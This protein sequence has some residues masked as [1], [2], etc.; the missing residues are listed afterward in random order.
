VTAVESALETAERDLPDGTRGSGVHRLPSTKRVTTSLLA[1]W[2]TLLV[3]FSALTYQLASGVFDGLT[4]AIREDLEWKTVRG[5]HD[6]AQGVDIGI[7]LQDEARISKAFGG[8]RGGR[9][10]MAIVAADADGNVVAQWGILPEPAAS[11]FSGLPNRVRSESRYLVS[12]APAATADR[13]V[14]R[15]ALAV[16]TARL[17]EGQTLRS[18]ILFTAGGASLVA[19]LLSLLFVNLY[20]RPVLN[21]SQRALDKLAELT[22]NLEKRVSDRTV[23]LALAN[24]KLRESLVK[25]HDTQRELV[26]SSRRTGMEDVATAVLHN[27][28]NVLNSVNVSACVISD[29]M[30]RSKV[31]RLADAVAILQT[32]EDPKAQQVPAYLSKLA[33]A[34]E[35]ERDTV[36]QE[37]DR[38]TRSVDHIKAV[39]TTQQAHARASL[40]VREPLQMQELIS[41]ALLVNQISYERHHIEILRELEELPPAMIDRHRV[42]QIL[43]NLLANAARAIKDG[44]RGDGR[45]TVRLQRI[46]PE[47]F[48]LEVEDTGVGIAPQ[49]AHLIFNHGFTTR[50]DGHGFGLHSSANAAQEMGGSLTC[51]SE[52]SGRGATFT[53]ELPLAVN[54]AAA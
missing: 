23:D 5:A 32:P 14:G 27:V 13:E 6:L 53:L 52:G 51:R 10:V 40:G 44:G 12:W 16:S 19:V 25:L 34:L 48:R 42:F 41:D 49:N 7:V 11:L 21:I 38:L 39:V 1:F 15:V 26:E 31:V 4:P 36:L 46:A 9:D 45:I 29:T 8:Y 22:R 33:E 43:N 3:A 28:G 17:R 54:R 35:G 47:A 50:K 24:A 2:I 37:L 30:N 18:R 20:F